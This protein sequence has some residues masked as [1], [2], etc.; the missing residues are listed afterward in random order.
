M[1][2]G[3]KIYPN[4]IRN[5]GASQ[6]CVESWILFSLYSN[7]FR[8]ERDSNTLIKYSDDEAVVACLNGV[9]FFPK[10]SAWCKENFLELNMCK[11]KELCIDFRTSGQFDGP[12][13]FGGET[14]EVTDT[15]KYLGITLD[16]KLTFGPRVQ[17]VYKKCQQRLYV[18]TTKF[19]SYC[20]GIL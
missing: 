7:D 12:L 4:I 8:S 15:F 19:Y 16:N 2:A 13:C 20:T 11:T 9:R 17:G 6:G 5:T 1:K 3:S 14:V 10:I 18:L